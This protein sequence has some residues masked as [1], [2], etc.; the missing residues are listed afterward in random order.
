MRLFLLAFFIIYELLI[1]LIGIIFLFFSITY[2]FL[3]IWLIII[4]FK[5]L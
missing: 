4:S 2:P 1:L 3:A 5:Y